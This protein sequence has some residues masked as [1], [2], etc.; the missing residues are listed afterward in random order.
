MP[1][2]FSFRLRFL[3]MLTV[4]GAGS[5]AISLVS[6]AG[7]PSDSVVVLNELMYHPAAV[8]GAE[9]CE[10]VELYNQMGVDV[11]VSGWRLTGGID[12]KFPDGTVIGGGEYL[13]V[14]S[15]EFTGSLDNGGEM[16]HLRDNSDR[17]MDSIDF[18]DDLPWPTGADGSG[19]SLAKVSPLRP[20]ADL[21]NWRASAEIGGTPG[22]ANFPLPGETESAVL[23]DW[24]A[25][26][27]YNES[28][29]NLG[30]SWSRQAH[31]PGGDWLQGPG[32][33]G[34]DSTEP[35]VPF[36]T[37]VSQP[38]K[39]PGVVTYY[40]ETEF[41]VTEAQ[42]G[43]L[44]ALQLVH[45]IDD[46][47]VFHLN[48][49]EIERFEMPGGSIDAGTL[50]T[51]R[52]DAEISNAITVPADALVAGENRLSAEVHQ[53][54]RTDSDIVF[55]MRL[56]VDFVPVEKSGLS[57]AFNEIS[58][59]GDAE[60][61]V[62]LT[63]MGA[64]LAPLEGYSIV[65]SEG[66]RFEFDGGTLTAGEFFTLDVDM[67]GFDPAS[68]DRFFLFHPGGK[69]LADARKVTNR[70]RGRS[71]A[72]GGRWLF[73]SAPTFGAANTF[74]FQEDIVINEIMYHARPTFS[75]KEATP[76]Y[77]D[78]TVLSG[79]ARWKY[80]QSGIFPGAD[81]M[82]SSFDD[83]AWP[84]GQGAL[85]KETAALP[86]P[87]RT[88]LAFGALTYYFRTTFNYTGDPAVDL[89]R[90]RLQVDDGA[91]IYINGAE[92]MRWGMPAGEIAYDTLASS[93]VTN[94]IFEKFDLPQNLLVTGENVIA[95]E[96]HQS[97]VGSSDVVFAMEV[98]S[99]TQTNPGI[100]AKK[101]TESAEEW[102]E[103]FNRSDAAIDLGGWELDGGIGYLFPVGTIL[104]AG[105]Y[106]VVAKDMAAFSAAH[107]VVP[108]I[109]GF[110][111]KL[112][113]RSDR[114]VLKDAKG[115]P[116]DEVSYFDGGR[117]D[118]S[119]DGH[120]P[121]LELRDPY[122]D[123][124]R[125]EAWQASDEAAKSDWRTYRYRVIASTP[126][127]RAPTLWREFAFGMLHG[128]GEVLLDDISVVEDPDSSAIERIQN[129]SFDGDSDAHWRLLGNHQRSFVE[130]GVLHVIASGATEYQGNQIETTLADRAAIKNG[131][132]Y[133]VS[134]RARWLSGSSQLNARLY[135]NRGPVTTELAVPTENG[136]PGA[137]NSR[138]VANAG[139]T[140]DRLQHS[141]RLPG[142]G[143]SVTVTAT[144][145]DPDGIAEATLHY[146]LE[147]AAWTSASMTANSSGRYSGRVPGQPAGSIVQIYVEATDGLGAISLVPAAGENSR[148]LFEVDDGVTADGEV[149]DLRAIMLESESD[150]LHLGTNSLSNELL[151]ATVIY[152]NEIFYDAGIRLKGS[153]VGRNVSRVGFNLKF[154]PDQLFRGVHDKVAVDR[155]AGGIGVDEIIIKHIAT[156]AGDIPGMYDDI[157]QFIAPRRQ[158]NTRAELRLAGFD[159]I[160]LDS[161]FD[162]GNDGTV[163]E[164]EVFRWAT[165]TV[166]G[167]EGLKRA[168]GGGDPNQYANIPFADFGDEKEDYRW[169]CLITTNR[170]R[171]DYS[172]VIPFLKAFVL[173]GSELDRAAPEVMDLDSV[174]RTLAYQSLVG[175]TDCTYTGG[176]DHNFRLYAR[177][178]GKMMYLPWD[179][180]SA[181]S[182]ST[183]A[184]LVG[185]G[186]LAK[187]VNRPTHLR[188]YHGH[189]KDIIEKAFN[190]NYM[191]AWTSHYGELGGQNFA[192]RL[193][194]IRS[195]AQFVL[196]RLPGQV[197]FAITSNGG[198]DFS[199]SEPT[200]IL[201]GDGWIDVAE[202]RAS[203]SGEAIAVTWTD[204]N[205]WTLTAPLTSGA[206][207]VTLRAFDRSG[208]EVGRDTIT[209]TNTGTTEAANASNLLISEVMYHP[210]EGGMEFVEVMNIGAS[211]ISLTG[212][213]FSD[214]IDFPF[215][216][217]LE[218][219]P[220]GRLVVT[221]FA[222]ETRLSNS[223]E[224]IVLAA[225]DGSVIRDFAYS[226]DLPW[227]AAP[228][229][230]GPSLVLINP[231]SNPDHALAANWR[232]STEAGGN[233]GDSDATTF[234]G[235]AGAD[236][237]GNGVGDLLDY[238][239]GHQAGARDGLP[240]LVEGAVFAVSY[241]E[242]LAADDVSLVPEW[243]TDLLIWHGIEPEGILVLSSL[244]AI[245][246][247]RQRVSFVTQP[248]VPAQW[249]FRLRAIQ[250]VP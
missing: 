156:R 190:A 226:D 131:A 68:G 219:A 110:S 73:P 157:V 88:N 38:S 66:D 223:G 202:I 5:G 184:S 176:A 250:I 245:E 128:E 160:Y 222:N 237:D 98:I 97:S 242:N 71:D 60:F 194:Y 210:A 177:P 4:L 240:S 69:K 178:D 111:G 57:L 208:N 228:D 119:A 175:P 93:S 75:T 58:P 113:N 140:F 168:G 32:P 133:E 232:S 34:W 39:N 33:I 29:A 141:P 74:S 6:A 43:G 247:G 135:F 8:E 198:D 137:R 100:P 62:E 15:A 233:P 94:A 95:V 125:G 72:M 189:L 139:P 130:D 21:A 167:P 46:G 109:G 63:N 9:E 147:G 143:Q 54:S 154:N 165:T 87:I 150:Y 28:G 138:F 217:G 13:L 166:G 24:G 209:V 214:G 212:A 84:S 126:V 10:W 185:G 55:G 164:F 180:D 148:A 51:G 106:L 92:A 11:D 89:L 23:L 215:A 41:N 103:L 91:V 121:S 1:P 64:V 114:I 132:E 82:K 238:A 142:A 229:G 224:R 30:E 181:F 241:T 12:F 182:R 112:G 183:S 53:R 162:N 127:R 59:A 26:W 25:D 145:S 78:E 197:P 123:N 22:G 205:S 105:D 153:F 221:D 152:G 16:I 99:A 20:T 195:R 244:T 200:V 124:A 134:F 3:C 201:A 172:I 19:A 129:G 81:W 179:W 50:S 248:A 14:S 37:R 31:A 249:Y 80:E 161:Q 187:L 118:E 90:L 48:G 204:S 56:L 213:R 52:R 86:E 44:T 83:S 76:T 173:S 42:F 171:D 191:A 70:L 116:A 120:G 108:A 146:R 231:L 163:Y 235:V 117:W 225:S 216:E 206:N 17:T 115:N 192:G 7:E 47:A 159:G 18:R 144:P 149:H 61:R 170:S 239:L 101:F 79:S 36:G 122:A 220:G 45:M 227:P 77:V 136:T 196:G 102:L 199:V 158:H 49:V 107:P 151:G 188:I 218:L 27:R 234:A 67:L 169:H 230:G 207:A 85:G 246:D 96:V 193:S 174:L 35:D 155:S 104:E 236:A 65:S 211:R 186:K 203:A 243:S 40:F 2:N